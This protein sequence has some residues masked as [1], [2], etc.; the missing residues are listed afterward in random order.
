MTSFTASASLIHNNL[1]VSNNGWLA[2]VHNSV[3]VGAGKIMMHSLPASQTKDGPEANQVTSIRYLDLANGTVLCVT[4]TNGSQIFNEDA[5]A[6]LFFAPITSDPAD[7]AELQKCHNAACVV[8]GLQHIVIGTF[9]GSLVLVHAAAADAF[10]AMPESAPGSPATEIADLCFCAATQT[11]FSAHANG[12]I[13]LWAPTPTGAYTNADA[14][15]GNGQAPVRIL[16][17]GT[18]LLVAYGPGTICLYDALSRELQVELTAHARWIT[19]VT[20]N[21]ELGQVA[22]VGEDTV[23]NVW[24]IDPASGRVGLQHSSVVTD[25]LLTGVAMH[26]AGVNAVAYDSEEIYKVAL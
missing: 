20:A 14:M 25:K 15:V 18:R 1:A 5:S 10:L 7:S 3:N 13:R 12:E 8:P 23:L 2:C 4:S 19:G 22:S 9:K 17:M 24:N 21:E 6:M 11:V 26:G 16:A